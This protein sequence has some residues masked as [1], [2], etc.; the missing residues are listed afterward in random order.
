MFEEPASNLELAEAD[1]EERSADMPARSCNTGLFDDVPPVIWRVFLTGW[2]VAF[3]LFVLF[4]ATDRSA[5]FSI[6]IS[7]L[8]VMMAFGLPIALAGQSSRKRKPGQMVETLSG[9]LTPWE[10]GAQIASIPMAA[11]LALVCFIVLAK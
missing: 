7:C 8:F 5:A 4:F 2:A 3:G 1:P 10:A 11:V 9:P 6:F